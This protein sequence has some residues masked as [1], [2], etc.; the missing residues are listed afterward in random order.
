MPGNLSKCLD[1]TEALV[2]NSSLQIITI[3]LSD[4][5][6]ESNES[7]ELRLT[8]VDS[9]PLCVAL[10][11]EVAHIHISPVTTII[12]THTTSDEVHS[13]WFSNDAAIS[14]DY[15]E[16]ELEITVNS[17]TSSVNALIP[18]KP[19]VSN[20]TD[21]VIIGAVVGAVA[22]TVLIIATTIII[23]LLVVIA[24]R[25]RVETVVTSNV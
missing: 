19:V 8:F 7:L 15:S 23:S 5:F 22:L 12:A 10:A 3:S 18:T 14:D 13:T 9:P 11:P 21:I 20:N 16:P 2:F 6:L 25:R 1:H 4:G 24:K 17:T